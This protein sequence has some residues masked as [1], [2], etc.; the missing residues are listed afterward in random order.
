M[1]K[2]EN[3]QDLITNTPS[4]LRGEYS[5]G[6]HSFN[7][8]YDFRKVLHALLFN[9]WAKI[10]SVKTFYG[11]DKFLEGYIDD[12]PKHNVHKSMKH[13]DGELCFGGGWFIVVAELPTGQITN[14]Y[15]MEDWDLFKIPESPKALI[16][17]DGHTSKD[18]LKRMQDYINQ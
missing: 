5:D 16:P 7:E 1:M 18:V 14:H 4:D 3:V 12:T 9:Q 13:H 6:Y 8:L 11:K 10:D 2:K 15:K 17:F